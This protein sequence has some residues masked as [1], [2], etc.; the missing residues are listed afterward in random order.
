MNETGSIGKFIFFAEYQ[1]KSLVDLDRFLLKLTDDIVRFHCTE[2][3]TLLGDEYQGYKETYENYL[4]DNNI[5]L[6]TLREAPFCNDFLL[7]TS[8]INRYRTENKLSLPEGIVKQEFNN[9]FKVSMDD[10]PE[11]KFPAIN[12][13]R[14][15]IGAFHK[16]APRPVPD[17]I[18]Q[19]KKR[20]WMMA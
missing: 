8:L 17:W 5:K 16:Y 1:P 6:G 11:T 9:L 13:L 7:G 4:R 14:Y 2:V 12:A 15:V 3:Y 19:K 10:S 18:S 20:S